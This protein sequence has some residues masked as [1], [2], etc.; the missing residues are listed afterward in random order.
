[1]KKTIK[2]KLFSC[3]F[4]F[5]VWI[6]PCFDLEIFN[7]TYVYFAIF[8]PCVIIMYLAKKEWVSFV[9]T[10]LLT[11]GVS[12]YN[13]EYIF[14]V[15]PVVLLI[16]AH[17]FIDNESDKKADNFNVAVNCA[18]L[19]FVFIVGQIIYSFIQY[20]KIEAHDIRNIFTV[21]RLAPALILFFSVLIVQCY[22][23][24]NARLIHKKKAKKYAMLYSVA[25]FGV[26]VHVFSVY[27]LNGYGIQS[28]RTE[29]I[30]WFSLILTMGANNDPYI[31]ITMKQIK[32][33]IEGNKKSYK[34]K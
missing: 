6:V 28:V 10:A 20:D 34:S 30:F 9:I 23:K 1:M 19:S 12:F 18:T 25:L 3:F 14:L 22:S 11:I 26:A 17:Y 32:D 24:K 31:D 27:A 5:A 33:L 2:R 8:V 15:L 16:Y 29:Y 4:L 13:Y 21:L 7:K